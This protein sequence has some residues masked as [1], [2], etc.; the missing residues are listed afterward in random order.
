MVH[1]QAIDNVVA[2]TLGIGGIMP[3]RGKS[4]GPRI[5]PV[6]SA[7][8]AEPHIT[9]AILDNRDHEVLERFAGAGPAFRKNLYSPVLPSMRVSPMALPTQM[10]S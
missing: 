1:H 5:V 3:E 7:I 9:G 10:F 8:G 2:Q 6:Q 4:A